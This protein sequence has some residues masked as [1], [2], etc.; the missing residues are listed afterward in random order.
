M[1]L[2][3]ASYTGKRDQVR[4]GGHRP[5]HSPETNDHGHQQQ[6]A[7]RLSIVAGGAVAPNYTI[8]YVAG[9]LTVLAAN[10]VA[11]LLPD[12]MSPGMSN[13]VIHG[14]G[15]DTVQS[16]AGKRQSDPGH[17]CRPQALPGHLQHDQHLVVDDLRGRHDS[18]W[19]E[20]LVKIPAILIGGPGNNTLMGGTGP[21]VLVGGSGNDTLKAGTGPTIMIAGSGH[22]TLYGNKGDNAVIG[23]STDYDNDPTSLLPLAEWGD[24]SAG[25]HNRVTYLLAPA[26]ARRRD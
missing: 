13:L 24:P 10:Q 11:T 6:P 16:A 17:Y 26:P 25:Y 7:G 2:L 8:S 9:T 23:G 18:L 14:S 15:N 4:Y 22:A 20:P 21:A 12:P 5:H 19:I 3:A 1:P